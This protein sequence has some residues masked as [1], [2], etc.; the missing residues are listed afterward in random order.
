MVTPF[1]GEV[2]IQKSLE[3]LGDTGA[4]VVTVSAATTFNTLFGGAIP[5]GARFVLLTADGSIRYT[6]GGRDP[7]TT[8]GHAVSTDK[9]PFW[10][11]AKNLGAVKI[12][13]AAG[14]VDVYA[15]AYY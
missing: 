9:M 12:I 7:T 15:E 1:Q 13:G 10:F 4:Q 8:F 6:T 3:F 14:N 2:V 5:A 11:D